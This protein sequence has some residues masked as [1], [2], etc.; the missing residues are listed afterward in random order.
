MAEF[1]SL[2]L[3]ANKQKSFVPNLSLTLCASQGSNRSA[4]ACDALRSMLLAIFCLDASSRGGW[5]KTLKIINY[6][7]LSDEFR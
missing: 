1:L 7:L 3:G 4:T 6:E 2:A 5:T